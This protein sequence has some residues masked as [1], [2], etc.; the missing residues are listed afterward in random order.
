MRYSMSIAHAIFKIKQEAA[1]DPGVL[2]FGFDEDDV[3]DPGAATVDE[4]PICWLAFPKNRETDICVDE[5][6]E[7]Y[8]RSFDRR[9]SKS[10]SISIFPRRF[11]RLLFRFLKYV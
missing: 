1:G 3:L 4:F 5:I 9:V 2:L 7:L 8:V 11:F 10:S 6:F